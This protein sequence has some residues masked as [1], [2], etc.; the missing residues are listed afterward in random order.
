MKICTGVD[1]VDLIMDVK[2]KIEKFQGYW[3]HWGQSLPFPIDF[4]RGPYQC[5]AVLS[6]IID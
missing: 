2:F 5:S 1:L 6:V 4:A 3:C